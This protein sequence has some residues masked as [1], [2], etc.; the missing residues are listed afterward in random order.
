MR[1]RMGYCARLAAEVS[2]C[3][4]ETLERFGAEFE[5]ALLPEAD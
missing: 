2:A 4:A 1:A 3:V 5:V